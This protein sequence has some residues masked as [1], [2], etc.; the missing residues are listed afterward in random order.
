MQVLVLSFR[1]EFILPL[2]TSTLVVNILLI[3]FN[4][5][6]FISIIIEV[7]M[8]LAPQQ[9]DIEYS[10]DPFLQQEQECIGIP[11]GPIPLGYG[12]FELPDCPRCLLDYSCHAHKPEHC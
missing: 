7:V 6:L 3:S 4:A 2:D 11:S 9:E 8:M 12:V 10:M 1:A 5:K